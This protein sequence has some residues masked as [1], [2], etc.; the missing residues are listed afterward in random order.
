MIQT[1]IDVD[2]I[3]EVIGSGGKVIQKIVAET[4]AKVDIQ[5]D[6]RIFI[7]AIDAE[8][9]LAAL[10]MIELIA[11]DP[12][13]GEIFSGKVTRIMT[14]GAFV[15]IAP[16]KEGLVHISKLDNR[17]V[18]KVE[19]VVKVG[20]IIKVKVMEVD[21]QGRINLSKKDAI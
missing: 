5:E 14:F 6:G 20:D 19:D 2:K 3:R 18:E 10:R 4:G 11:K 21:D 16:G 1:K 17:R 7:A 12:P 9:G 15:E 8:S 13:I